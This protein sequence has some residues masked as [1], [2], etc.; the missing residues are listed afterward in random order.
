M[1]MNKNQN[2]NFK[3]KT[4]IIITQKNVQFIHI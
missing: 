4:K 1:K 3:I 2:L